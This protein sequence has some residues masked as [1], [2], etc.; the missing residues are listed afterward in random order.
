MIQLLKRAYLLAK[1]M[2][3][4][5]YHFSQRISERIRYIINYR[6][7]TKQR[8]TDLEEQVQWFKDHAD[9]MALKPATG[10]LRDKQLRTE[11]FAN[12]FFEEIKELGIKPFLICGNLIGAYRHKG[13]V[14]WDD[15]LD[16]GLMRDDYEKLIDFCK[17]NYSVEIYNGKWSEYSTD[18]HVSRMD[19]AIREHPDEYILDIWVDQIQITRGTS[20]ID[21]LALDF[22]SFDYYADD[23]SIEDH[24]QYLRE[25]SEKKKKI[26]YVDKIVEFLK[27]ERINN[28]VISK[29]RT[30]IIFPG[31]DNVEG[32]LRIDQTKDWLYTKDTLPLKK[33]SYESSEYWV[34]NNMEKWLEY[35][36]PDY[37]DFPKDVGKPKHEDYTEKY[38]IS[39]L[40]Y[41]EFYLIDAFEIYHF[42][43]LYHFFERNGIFSY[44][45]AEKPKKTEHWLDYD[46]AIKILELNGVRYKN[47]PDYNADYVFT[48][49]DELNI[50]N[51]KNKKINL[52]YGFG[53]LLN[54]YCESERST[55]N[56]NL[57]LVH[58]DYSYNLIKAKCP[59]INLIK[60]GYPKY[61][62][63]ND[64]KYVYDTNKKRKQLLE[65]NIDN[66]PVLLYF[67]TWGQDS[68][69]SVYA[70]GF[71]KLR[72]KFF[73]ITKAHHCTYRLDSEKEHRNILNDI[74]DIVLEGNY[75]FPDAVALGNIAVCDAISGSATEV[76][77]LNSDTKLVLLYSPIKEK[78][79]YKD[80]IIDY[81]VHAEN[82]NQ[83]ID[84]VNQLETGDPFITKRK[85]LM[86]K[87]FSNDTEQGLNKLKE[88]I[89][90]NYRKGFVQ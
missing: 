29:E 73:I 20:C 76:P 37:M 78:N 3:V 22:W 86:D 39:H 80:I 50:R 42:L 10:Y 1:K 45:V 51:Y 54:D 55:K 74:S 31:I 41:V 66:K 88:Y 18:K 81:A 38:I 60:V 67:P 34:P 79:K 12:D 21:R 23:Y 59:V 7:E 32:F 63:W 24:M 16:F 72:K 35:E 15:D 44:F 33:I 36:Y 8:I 69:I 6:T 89:M 61:T 53:F 49:Q 82:S 26:D 77:F 57:K 58:G 85:L 83:L 13:F 27:N 70:S 28:P 62:Y 65:K 84:L 30:Q 71:K 11:Q 64:A 68:S 48:T 52:C 75:S 4:K 19:H 14:P 17:K 46:T 25:L 2:S 40:P 47:N 9:I 43:P 90:S 56:F 5:A 87:I